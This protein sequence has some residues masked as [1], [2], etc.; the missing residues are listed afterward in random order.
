MAFLDRTA[1]QLVDRSLGAFRVTVVN[2][3]RQA[4]KSTLLALTYAS[5][6]GALVSLD[7]RAAL[8]LARTDPTGMLAAYERP[9]FIDEVQ[10]GGDPLILAVKVAVDA[11]ATPGRFVL[12]GSSRFL[13]VPTLTES[14]AGRV[15]IVDLWPL[16]QGEI[17]GVEETFI[18]RCFAGPRELM[19]ASPP[20]ITRRDLARRIVVGGFPTVQ[21][22]RPQDRRD[23]FDDYLRTL[24]ERDL[25]ELARLRRLAEMSTLVRLVASNTAQEVAPATLAPATGL[26]RETVA[27]YLALLETIYLVHRLPAW[28]GSETTRAKRKPKLHMVDSG[29]ACALQRVAEERLV[30]PLFEGIGPLLE[31]FVVGELMRQRAW[32][33]TR[34]A[35]FHYRDRD[36]REID[37]VLEDA[38]GRIVGI[39]VKAAVDVD[40]RDARWLA[41]M[42]DRVGGRFVAGLVLHLGDR[43]KPLGDRLVAMPL[44]ALWTP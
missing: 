23:W 29:V 27:D 1:R 5:T 31:S 41:H 11:D 44:A 39:E 34:P 10:R 26:T 3:P 21:Q 38:E 18:D 12:A 37:V 20:P 9:L 42:R 17:E 43:P 32:S 8:R 24:M 33:E 28:A 40:D 4:G 16:S 19:S 25:L 6:G 36:K 7:D 22:L 14:L 30:D 2:G 13:T 35:M 15:R